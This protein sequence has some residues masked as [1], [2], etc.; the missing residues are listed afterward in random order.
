MIKLFTKIGYRTEPLSRI[1][2]DFIELALKRLRIDFMRHKGLTA[3]NEH[4]L[5]LNCLLARLKII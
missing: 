5:N 3:D 4:L 2:A 1:E